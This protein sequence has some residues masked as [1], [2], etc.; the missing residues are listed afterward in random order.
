[1][2]L[3]T[4]KVQPVH[5]GLILQAGAGK[6]S[7]LHFML[8]QMTSAILWLCLPECYTQCF[9]AM[10]LSSLSPDCINKNPDVCP[11]G[12][13][14]TSRRIIAKA[15]LSVTCHNIQHAAG[16]LQLCAGQIFG[17]Y[18]VIHTMSHLF[19]DDASKAVLLVDVNNGFN[20]LNRQTALQNI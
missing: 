19:S 16:T 9:M 17:I 5:L 2:Q 13:C 1:M 14:E 8:N 18:A 15:I 20:L 10:T 12:I 6:D 11:I 7:A 4:L 3:S